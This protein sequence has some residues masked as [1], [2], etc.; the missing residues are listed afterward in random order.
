MVTKSPIEP[1]EQA[2]MALQRFSTGADV[3]E[4][5]G[6]IYI[7]RLHCAVGNIRYADE[8]KRTMYRRARELGACRLLG[9]VPRK[10]G[11]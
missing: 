4:T 3:H 10:I 11:R 6:L 7:Y 5:N 9:L 1:D 8:A 2:I